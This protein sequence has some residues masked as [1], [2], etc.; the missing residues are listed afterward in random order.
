MIYLLCAVA[1]LQKGVAIVVDSNMTR[2]EA[3]G[4]NHF[5]ADVLARMEVVTVTYNGFNH[6]RRQG[7]IV[8]DR[9]IAKEV[10]QIFDEIQATGYPITKV[11]PIVAYGWSDDA[12]IADNNTSA[13]NYRHVIGPGQDTTKLSVHAYGRAIDVNPKINPFVAADGS[14]SR[15]YDPSKPGV[16]TLHSPV[17]QI[18][19]RHGWEW[20][21]SWKTGRD[22]QHF[23]KRR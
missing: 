8:V 20:G 17:T 2:A 14:T 6:I 4:K 12:S 15:P 7:Q 13:F 3:L 21:G 22:Y 23:D 16:L 5:P 19:L 1:Y 11:V 10:K 18:F 9:M